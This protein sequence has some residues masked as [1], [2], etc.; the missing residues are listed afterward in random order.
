MCN[1]RQAGRQNRLAQRACSRDTNFQA[2]LPASGHWGPRSF[3]PAVQCW[4][5]CRTIKT[6]PT[7]PTTAH[8]MLDTGSLDL[9]RPLHIIEID[10]TF[11]RASRR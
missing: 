6:R 4:V 9:S 2:I 8:T 7:G 10:V 1:S 3:S 5:G 11:Q